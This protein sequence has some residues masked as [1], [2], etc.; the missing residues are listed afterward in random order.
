MD[1]Q[2]MHTKL[3]KMSSKDGLDFWAAPSWLLDF[4]FPSYAHD[5]YIFILGMLWHQHCHRKG[6]ECSQDKPEKACC[7]AA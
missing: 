2:M 1:G 4:T 7:I 3:R 5:N 6:S